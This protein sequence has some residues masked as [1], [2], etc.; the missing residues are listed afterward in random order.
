MSRKKLLTNSGSWCIIKLDNEIKIWGDFVYKLIASDVDGTLMGEDLVI[1]PDNYKA[2]TSAVEK[3]FTFVL[4]SG[5]SHKSLRKL[6]DDLGLPTENAYIISFNG[7]TVYSV[8]QEAVVH[9]EHT[10]FDVAMRAIN[11]F[12]SRCRKDEIEA[13][14]YNDPDN[15]ATEHGS[16]TAENYSKISQTEIRFV[17]NIQR[18]T[19]ESARV[20]K[21][22]FI[23]RREPLEVF[24]KELM[25]ELGDDAEIFFSSEYLL[26]IGSPK[27]SKGIALG[28]LCDKLGIDISQ[29][30]AM[31]DNYNDLTMIETAGMGVAVANSV[32]ELKETANHITEK[33]AEQGA[34]AEVI[35]KFI[36]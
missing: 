9:E 3:G 11:L 19:E 34:V 28:W 1:H 13:F 7:G 31:G 4:C 26:E 2:I 33:T 8:E 21:V 22:V 5:R 10:P 36:L 16:K 14:V 30:I 25:A 20:V 23:G 35:N 15:I 17:D 18:D 27:A 29:T 32:D 24:R 6:H 12:K